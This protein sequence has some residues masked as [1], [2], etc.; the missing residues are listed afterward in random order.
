[1]FWHLCRFGQIKLRFVNRSYSAGSYGVYRLVDSPTKTSHAVA[2]FSRN[3]VL[4]PCSRPRALL[5]W[6]KAGKNFS[7]LNF[8]FRSPSFV[9][10][11]F[12]DSSTALCCRLFASQSAKYFA[13]FVTKTALLRP[14]PSC[15]PRSLGG[16]T[17]CSTK[18]WVSIYSA[19]QCKKRFFHLFLVMLLP[20]SI[21][22]LIF[23]DVEPVGLATTAQPVPFFLLEKLQLV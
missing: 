5:S 8:F 14:R 18:Y 11:I 21:E 1:M 6:F 4:S 20:S 10:T 2:L 7:S 17:S 3:L 15:L 19:W 12:T 9:F 22:G 23:L 16:S 13:Y